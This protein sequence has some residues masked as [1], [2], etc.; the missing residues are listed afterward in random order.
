MKFQYAGRRQWGRAM[1]DDLTDAVNWAVQQGFAPKD[2]VAIYGASYGGYA[3]L[4]GLVFTPELYRCGINY[5]GAVDLRFL[6][7]PS[8]GHGRW[9]E[10]YVKNWIGEDA[11]DLR[12]RSPVEYVERIRVPTMHAYGE[13]DPRVDIDHWNELQSELRKY[14]KPYT[15]FRKKEEGHGFRIESDRFDFYRAVEKFLAENLV[16][17]PDGRVTI[18]P[19]KVEQMPALESR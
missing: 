10:L 8:R 2:R 13:N 12:A 18:G 4:A 9:G 7:R 19:L 1:Q 5:V 14:H 16:G 15:Y 11:A 6:V 17:G 3:V